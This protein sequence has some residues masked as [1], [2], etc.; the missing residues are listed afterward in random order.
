MSGKRLGKLWQFYH[1]GE[2]QNSKHHKCYCHGCVAVKLAL[3]EEEEEEAMEQ[4][5]AETLEDEWPDDGAI[6]INSDEEYQ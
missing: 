4:A 1:K 5:M 2:A 6:E 3:E